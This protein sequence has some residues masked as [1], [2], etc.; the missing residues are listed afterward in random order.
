[1]IATEV[2]NA[3]VMSEILAKAQAALKYCYYATEYTP[4][5]FICKV[6]LHRNYFRKL[7]LSAALK[8]Y[9][10]SFQE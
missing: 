10:P 6:I 8:Y 1:M 4:Y 3:V 2:A 9:V 5:I 7:H